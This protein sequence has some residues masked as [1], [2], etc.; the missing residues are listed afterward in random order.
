MFK[1]NMLTKQEIIWILIT[2]LLM[3]FV[4][5][6][7]NFKSPI[8]VFAI[9]FV[10][11]L[12]NILAKKIAAKYYYVKIEHSILDFQRF[13]I[14]SRSYLK[15]PFPIGL[16]FPFLLSILSLGIIKPFLFL[17]FKAQNIKTRILKRRGPYRYSEINESDLGFV[18]AWGFWALI[19]LAIIASILNISELTRYSIYYGIWNLI[20]LGKLDGIKLFFGSLINWIILAIVYIIALVMVIII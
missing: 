1:L 12:V 4:I 6:F 17:Q 9:S 11:I 10:I 13:G 16:V 14:Y 2:I 20:P 3:G 15:K 8:F 19:I 5:S 18:S 7:P